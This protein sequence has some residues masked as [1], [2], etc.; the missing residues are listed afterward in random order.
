VHAGAFML[1]SPSE[2]EEEEEEEEGLT[3]PA[4]NHSLRAVDL[5]ETHGRKTCTNLNSFQL[6]L[7]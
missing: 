7:E 3:G 1:T 2:E 5:N 6:P 4:L